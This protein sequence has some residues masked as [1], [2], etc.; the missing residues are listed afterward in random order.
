MNNEPDLEIKM[1][2]TAR[3]LK[4]KKLTDQ[5]RGEFPDFNDLAHIA[6]RVKTDMEDSL[7]G[8]DDPTYSR[9]DHLLQESVAW[10]RD[11]VN[12]AVFPMALVGKWLEDSDRE[13]FFYGLSALYSMVNNEWSLMDKAGAISTDGI[14]AIESLQFMQ[15]NGRDGIDE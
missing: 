2:Q 3:N 9:C 1:K 10:F 8:A 4:N 7:K 13:A 5:W 14:N 12:A 6:Q 15:N 11:T